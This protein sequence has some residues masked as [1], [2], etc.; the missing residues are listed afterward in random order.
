ML[1]GTLAHAAKRVPLRFSKRIGN[2]R[3]CRKTR[4]NRHTTAAYS[5][6]LSKLTWEEFPDSQGNLPAKHEFF[7]SADWGGGGS[8]ATVTFCCPN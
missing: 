5:T 8:V 2:A 4:F 3:I 7:L 1:L 6:A